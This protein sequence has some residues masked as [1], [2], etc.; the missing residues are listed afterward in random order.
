ML[1]IQ[2]SAPYLRFIRMMYV[3]LGLPLEVPLHGDIVLVGGNIGH[4]V[5]VRH[6]PDRRGARIFAE[7]IRFDDELSARQLAV[8]LTV[9][10]IGF[11]VS[12]IEPSRGISSS[13]LPSG[14]LALILSTLAS[15]SCSMV[16]VMDAA[17]I[18]LRLTNPMPCDLRNASRFS[19][20]T[21]THTPL[22]LS[23]FC[24]SSST[25]FSSC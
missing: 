22:K 3:S 2:Q 4:L 24:L 10:P 1:C 7:I 8:T 9:S 13:T 23:P 18:S 21:N 5:L 14:S 12:F 16:N 15:W 6:S 20:V 25:A 11:V 19:F 17:A